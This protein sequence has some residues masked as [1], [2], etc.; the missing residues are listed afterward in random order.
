MNN[1]S[2]DNY[3]KLKK[4]NAFIGNPADL[5]TEDKTIV[6]AINEI[7][8]SGGS[9]VYIEEYTWT[10]DT[11]R[12]PRSNLSDLVITHNLGVIPTHMIILS[13]EA[14]DTQGTPSNQVYM[15]N[16][17]F[18]SSEYLTADIYFSTLGTSTSD[19]NQRTYMRTSTDASSIW[20][21]LHATETTI[22]PFAAAGSRYQ[23]YIQRNKKILFV[24]W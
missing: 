20:N 17:Y 10:S 14:P 1:F 23:G 4:I 8:E 3:D 12:V 21:A 2:I 5:V 6:G 9:T 15:P 18:Q 11:T 19:V 7:S 24:I 16:G 22:T 13:I